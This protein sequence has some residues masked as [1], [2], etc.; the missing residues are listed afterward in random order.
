MD[1]ADE[2][3]TTPA[4]EKHVKEFLCLDG[5]WRTENGLNVVYPFHPVS[6][7]QEYYHLFDT[8][9][10]G[11]DKY[12]HRPYFSWFEATAFCRW[13]R[14]DNKSC[15][16]LYREEIERF[17]N[18]IFPTKCAYMAFIEL[19]NDGHYAH[20]CS[21][22][23]QDRMTTTHDSDFEQTLDTELDDVFAD[24]IFSGRKYT[25][26][27]ARNNRDFNLQFDIARDIE[28]TI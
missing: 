26:P 16:M 25:S 23:S 13:L 4:M 18:D 21:L 10:D 9:L 20:L 11:P 2:Y 22:G 28:D 5:C 27:D 7:V 12:R 14:W 6:I 8:N 15:R 3:F 1:L 17:A 24:L 19:S